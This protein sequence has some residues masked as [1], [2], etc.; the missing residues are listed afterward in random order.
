MVMS[1][2]GGSGGVRIDGLR[3]RLVEERSGSGEGVAGWSVWVGAVPLG[4]VETG[5]FETRRYALVMDR[6]MG[7]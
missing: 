5:S 4:M 2:E 7:E 3:R 6:V 1:C